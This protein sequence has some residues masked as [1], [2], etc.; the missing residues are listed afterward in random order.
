MFPG[1]WKVVFDRRFVGVR[2]VVNF[3]KRNGRSMSSNLFRSRGAALFGAAVLGLAGSAHG[4]LISG[5]ILTQ[6]T[7]EAVT[8]SATAGTDPAVTAGGTGSSIS[9]DAGTV[10]G[11]ATGHHTSASTVF[12]T[13]AGNGS[14][15]A[16]SSNNWSVGDYYQFTTNTSGVTGVGIIFD[17]TGS[18]TG[19][20]DFKV[21]YSTDGSTFLDLTGAS[22]TL[23]LVTFGASESSNQPPRF[24]FSGGG[25]LDNVPSLMLRLV[26]TS[27]V[28]INAGAVAAAG[29]DR[30][31]NFTIGTNLSP[32]PEPSSLG[33]LGVGG[34]LAFR[35][36]RNPTSV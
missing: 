4:S 18:G 23:T 22:Y 33:L 10:S 31:D 16:F 5:N 14:T 19:P 3:C 35:R 26:D 15:K 13:P 1:A 30:V 25:V 28:N 20:R 21:Q 6:Y 7:F 8:V 24:Q 34:L 32:V 12:S 36:R 2:S 9:S 27:T 11:S 17:Q 29:T